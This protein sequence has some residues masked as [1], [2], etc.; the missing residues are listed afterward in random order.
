MKAAHRFKFRTDETCTLEALSIT[1]PEW[2]VVAKKVSS[3]GHDGPR[4]RWWQAGSTPATLTEY[5]VWLWIPVWKHLYKMKSIK[6][7]RVG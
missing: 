7:F 5:L 2:D 3:W 1:G 4:Q 6:E